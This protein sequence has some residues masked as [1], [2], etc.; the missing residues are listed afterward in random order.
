MK[1][2][3]NN[4]MNF[5]MEMYDIAINIGEEIITW[6]VIIIIILFMPLVLIIVCIYK[7]LIEGRRANDHKKE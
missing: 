5:I 3:K 7:N 4:I 2:L 1:E 6:I